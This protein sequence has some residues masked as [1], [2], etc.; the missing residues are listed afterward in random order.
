MN[1]YGPRMDDQGAYVSVIMKV[2]DRIA[3]GRPPVVFGDGSQSYDFVYVLDAARAN[4]LALKS[5]ATDVF[6]NVGTGVQT[7]INQ[8]VKELLKLEG[9]ELEIQYLPQE[10]MFVTTRLGSTELAATEIG[11]IAKTPLQQG[12]RA[13]VEWQRKHRATAADAR[14]SAEAPTAG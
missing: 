3:A 4:A 13:V 5:P 6:L 11:F 12:L 9:S 8:L 14:L 2:L 10:Q 1:I 7:T